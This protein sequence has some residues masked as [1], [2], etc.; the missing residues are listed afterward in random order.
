MKFGM[1]VVFDEKTTWAKCR[2]DRV[3][4]SGIF[5]VFGFFLIIAQLLTGLN[6]I[7]YGG[8]V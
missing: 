7:W 5:G 4:P 1:G 3:T 2:P 6:E 8:S